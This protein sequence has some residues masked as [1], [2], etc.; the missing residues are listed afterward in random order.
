MYFIA[1]QEGHTEQLSPI[2]YTKYD[3]IICHGAAKFIFAFL[4]LNSEL[5]SVVILKC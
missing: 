2:N 3:Q 1:V 4:E 5:L